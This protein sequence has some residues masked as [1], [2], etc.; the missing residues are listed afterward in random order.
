MYNTK[1]VINVHIYL[2]ILYTYVMYDDM[3]NKL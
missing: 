3:I 2:Y 1:I